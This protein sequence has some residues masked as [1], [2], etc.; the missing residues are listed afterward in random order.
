MDV[1][2]ISGFG[3]RVRRL[4]IFAKGNLDVR[5]TLH[6]LRVGGEVKWNGLNTALRDRQPGVVS[7]VRHEVLTR[8][9]ALLEAGG[10]VPD[11]LAARALS[12][13]DFPAEAQFS[14]ALFE[15]DA[16]AVILSIQPDITV[17]LLRHRREGYAFHPTDWRAWPPEDQAWL[18]DS[19]RG[20]ELLDVAASMANFERIV[21][22]L[23]ERSDRPILIYNVSAVSAGETIHTHLGA[24]ELLSTRIRRFNLGLIELSQR[25]GV[26]IIDVDRIVAAGG[27]ARMKYDTLHLS[28]E[29]C[30]A[31]AAEVARVLDDLGC[32]APAELAS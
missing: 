29:G 9:D 17:G 15:T 14:R 19:F 11:S 30:R 13:G 12:L 24:E 4:T 31:V 5:D 10:K 16:D 25:T 2:L 8:S 3:G 1:G 6:A 18:W 20:G 26:S 23:R 27:A 7:R 32:L 21:A 22:R 28:P